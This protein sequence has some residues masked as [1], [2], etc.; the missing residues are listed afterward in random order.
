MAAA[1]AEATEARSKKA[2]FTAEDVV[3]HL[4]KFVKGEEDDALAK[5]RI[6]CLELLGKNFGMFKPVGGEDNPL[7]IQ[8][9]TRRIVDGSGDSD[10]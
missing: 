2:E 7:V 6:R 3:R 10:S 1:I 5:D 4:L 9:V 8:Q